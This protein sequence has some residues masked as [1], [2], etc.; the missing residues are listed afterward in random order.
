MIQASS[1]FQK[2]W[3]FLAQGWQGVDWLLM[4]LPVVLVGFA[5]LVISSIQRNLNMPELSWNHAWL[6]LICVL[7]ALWVARMRY[8]YLLQWQWII[9][10][11]INAALILVLFIGTIGSGA[12]SWINIGG[13]Y[14][15]P[16]EF[17]K[18]SLIISLAA[19]LSGR[20]ASSLAGVVR[21]LAI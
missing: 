2:R 20:G 6:G 21:A 15:Q 8:E 4:V 9:Y 13:F 5:T 17:A 11:I 3:R 16:S 7:I 1:S 14:V 18:I 10:A 12:Q 19:A